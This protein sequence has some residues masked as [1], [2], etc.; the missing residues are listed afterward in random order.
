ME[1]CIKTTKDVFESIGDTLVVYQCCK[2]GEAIIANI[3]D[4]KLIFS[5]GVKDCSN[6]TA[7][8]KD[9]LEMKAARI[10]A[11]NK[12]EI[13]VNLSPAKEIE[14]RSDEN[15]SIFIPAKNISYEAP[16]KKNGIASIYKLLFSQ[17]GGL[18]NLMLKLVIASKTAVESMKYCVGYTNL[19]EDLEQV[20]EIM[21]DNKRAVEIYN[22]IASEDYDSALY[23]KKYGH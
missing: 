1:K 7:C 5:I 17:N 8:P 11:F 2:H 14:K 6:P 23:V 16:D 13:K 19:L 10:K 15:P 4:K 12:L 22:S 3:V 21:V 9:A 18:E 20:G